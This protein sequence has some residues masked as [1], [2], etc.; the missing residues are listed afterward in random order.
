MCKGIKEFSNHENSYLIITTH[1][2]DEKYDDFIVPA[3]FM[4]SNDLAIKF[5]V[6]DIQT[7]IKDPKYNSTIVFA[8]AEN[9]NT[10]AINVLKDYWDLLNIE[11]KNNYVKY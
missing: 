7:Y 5:I 1:Q 2:N 11:Y 8:L 10:K 3:L 4:N 9:T 6:S